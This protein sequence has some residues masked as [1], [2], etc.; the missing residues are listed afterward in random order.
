MSFGVS[1]EFLGLFLI[2]VSGSSC[3][4]IS[5]AGLFWLG[6]TELFPLPLPLPSSGIDP[7]GRQGIDL[8]SGVLLG[9]DGSGE[10]VLEL[11]EDKQ[12]I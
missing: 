11:D 3:V 8:L 10:V 6:V 4:S 1:P 5:L 12:M 2:W 7:G 9:G